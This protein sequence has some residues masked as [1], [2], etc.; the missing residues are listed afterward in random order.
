M[1]L[2][3]DIE[4]KVSNITKEYFKKEL[5]SL[6]PIKEGEVNIHTSYVYLNGNEVEVSVIIRNGLNN[7]INFEKLPILITDE[8]NNIYFRA[9]FEATG[10]G[11]IPPF[12][13][14]PWKFYINLDD[15]FIKDVNGK[16]LTVKFDTERL[17]A[18]VND[19]NRIDLI[20]P[21]DINEGEK[22]AII[23]FI[24]NMPPL[25]PKTVD[26]DVVTKAY[27]KEKETL[28]LT[29]IV[30]NGAYEDVK[31][32]FLPYNYEKDG[33]VKNI[34]I[35]WDGIIIPKR[36]IRAFKFEIKGIRL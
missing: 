18:E 3:P 1:S 10:I 6:E 34:R 29:Y 16:K 25:E 7:T 26:L 22:Q 33:E 19:P 4:N 31:L 2:H 23:E 20:L 24:K 14:R 5:E 27:S 17:K 35:E 30:R 21:S 15:M 32:D 11:D 36:S 13:A 12:K 9:T 28:Y 8:D